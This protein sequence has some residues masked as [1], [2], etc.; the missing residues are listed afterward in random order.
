L[1]V[2][3]AYGRKSDWY[4]NLLVGPQAEVNHRGKRIKVVAETVSIET[5]TEEFT[6]YA[7]DHPR[8][9]R[10]LG[11]LMGI[12]FDDPRGVAEKIPLVALRPR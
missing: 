11:K 12:P 3:A 1:Y 7:A 4:R 5:A 2:P 9:A 6:R 10:N 8:S